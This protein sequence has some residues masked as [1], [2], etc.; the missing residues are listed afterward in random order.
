MEY[1]REFTQIVHDFKLQKIELKE[2]LCHITFENSGLEVEFTLHELY[3]ISIQKSHS[4]SIA[5]RV[6][7]VEYDEMGIEKKSVFGDDFLELGERERE[8]YKIFSVDFHVGASILAIVKRF[9]TQER[10]CAGS[11]KSD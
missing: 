11:E 4:S 9:S 1:A 6:E 8:S 10:E 2:D 3:A 5:S 7:F